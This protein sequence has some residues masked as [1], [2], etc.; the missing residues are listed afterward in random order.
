MNCA[1]FCRNQILFL[2]E[3]NHEIAKQIAQE[4]NIHP[5]TIRGWK[6]RNKIPDRYLKSYSSDDLENLV[7][8]LNHR[9]IKAKGIAIETGVD[10]TRIVDFKR[11][12]GKPTQKEY[13]SIKECINSIASLDTRVDRIHKILNHNCLMLSTLFED[14]NAFRRALWHT[15]AK[16]LRPVLKA[17]QKEIKL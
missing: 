4:N 10:L 9:A 1:F 7:S 17:F 11:E 13:E 2:M 15:D 14:Y 6:M 8:V 5:S 12:K 16:Y 3:Y